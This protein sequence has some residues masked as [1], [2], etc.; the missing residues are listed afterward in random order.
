MDFAIGLPRTRTGYD[1]IW[2]I[3]DQ[4]NKLAYFLAIRNNFTLD[5]LAKLYINEVVELNGVL[6]SIVSYRDPRFTY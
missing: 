3:V 1:A 6:V 5:K 2:V 4:L